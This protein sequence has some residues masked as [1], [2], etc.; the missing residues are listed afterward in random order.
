M[1]LSEWLESKKMSR[2]ELARR[3]K[4]H[5]S[6]ISRLANGKRAPSLAMMQGIN[7]ETGGRVGLKDWDQPEKS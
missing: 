7:K 3:L 4:V 1:K 2:A 5:A 6:L